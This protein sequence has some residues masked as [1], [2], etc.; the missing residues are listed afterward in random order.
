MSDKNLYAWDWIG[1]GYNQ[2]YA[3]SEE[4]AIAEGNAMCDGKDGSLH[5]E[6]NMNTFR[7]VDDVEAFWDNYPI[8]D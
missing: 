3:H 8:F 1:G 4:E 7:K 6:I 5:L 2:T